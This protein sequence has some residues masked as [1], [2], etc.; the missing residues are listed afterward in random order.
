V[1]SVFWLP[2]CR[3]EHVVPC[4]ADSL[5][6]GTWVVLAS[7]TAVSEDTDNA[8]CTPGSCTFRGESVDDLGRLL[9][10]VLSRRLRRTDTDTHTHRLQ[11]DTHRSSNS[12]IR[13]DIRRCQGTTFDPSSVRSRA[14]P[15]DLKSVDTNDSQRSV[16]K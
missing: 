7:R 12:D 8:S 3:S 5:H 10:L 1:G 16:W 6:S 2:W 14:C 4:T 13:S 15:S 11:E 9:V